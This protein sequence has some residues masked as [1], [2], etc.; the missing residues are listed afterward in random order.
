[1]PEPAFKERDDHKRSK[2]VINK[3]A[4]IDTA[5]TVNPLFTTETCRTSTSCTLSQ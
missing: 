1:M 3:L 4:V 2:M 5:K